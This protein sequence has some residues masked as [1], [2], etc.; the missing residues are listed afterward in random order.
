VC[1]CERGNH[2]LAHNECFV[3]VSTMRSVGWP[4]ILIWTINSQG[5][6]TMECSLSCF[7]SET[8][9]AVSMTV[10]FSEGGFPTGG[11]VLSLDTL[12]SGLSDL[13][14][15]CGPLGTFIFPVPNLAFVGTLISP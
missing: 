13:L 7:S 3:P 11:L 9:R 6:S 8:F 1:F 2:W 10:F 15:V 4:P 14:R 12:A 5:P